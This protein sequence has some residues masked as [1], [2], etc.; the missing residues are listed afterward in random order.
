MAEE[1]RDTI[2]DD[3]FTVDQAFDLG[4]QASNYKNYQDVR[5]HINKFGLNRQ[6]W[7]EVWEHLIENNLWI[8]VN[9]GRHSP[10]TD[11]F[12]K[13]FHGDGPFEHAQSVTFAYYPLTY[14]YFLDELSEYSHGNQ[15]V[16]I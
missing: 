14:G 16:T 13:T 1:I 2:Y 10:F 12:E 6:I 4:G 9:I 5:L 8:R 15:A 7:H 3:S 11:F